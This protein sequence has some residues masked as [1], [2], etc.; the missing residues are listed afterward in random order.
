MN[1]KEVDLARQLIENLGGPFKPEQFHDEY[2][3]NVERLIEQKQKGEK[4]AAV[5]QPKPAPVV[6]ILQAL[7]AS[8]KQPAGKAKKPAKRTGRAA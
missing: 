2:R 4:P 1:Q 8:L 6:D 7:Q 5:R 3:A